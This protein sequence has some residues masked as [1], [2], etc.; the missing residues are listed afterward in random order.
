MIFIK[1]INYFDYLA[2]KDGLAAF[3]RIETAMWGVPFFCI[4]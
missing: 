3:C 2:K 4:L 1:M